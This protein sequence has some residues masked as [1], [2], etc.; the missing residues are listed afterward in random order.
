MQLAGLLALPFVLI[1][2]PFFNSGLELRVPNFLSEFGGFTATG[3][4]PDF[5][6]LPFNPDDYRRETNYGGKCREESLIGW[7]FSSLRTCLPEESTLSFHGVVLCHPRN[8]CSVI[9]RNEGSG[10]VHKGLLQ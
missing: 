7:T 2:F 5:H 3:I 6:R 1:T 10:I 9:P 8:P 4:A